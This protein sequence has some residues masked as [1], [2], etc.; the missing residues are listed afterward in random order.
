M[1]RKTRVAKIA[2]GTNAL[3]AA[4]KFSVG[5]MA[6]S[7]ALVADAADS[8]SDLVG[9]I[10]L[11]LGLSRAEA[12]PDD[13]HPYGHGKAEC[14]ASL[15]LGVLILAAAVT[16]LVR[17]ISSVGAAKHPVPGS[18]A[19]AAA[20]FSII[21]N[22]ALG[23]Y[24]HRSSKIEH[25]PGLEAGGTH[26]LSDS[27]TSVAALIGIYLARRGYP[28]ADPIVAGI[29][30]LLVGRVAVGIILDAGN[31]LMDRAAPEEIVRAVRE[32]ATG[33][34]GIWEVHSIRSRCSGSNYLLDLHIQVGPSISVLDGHELGHRLEE[35]ILSEVPG[36]LEVIVHVEPYLPE[37]GEET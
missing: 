30:S 16:L 28:L 4:V 22:L 2:I 6:K 36:V 18:L 26:A 14:L 23:L 12:P 7:S 34:P 24:M 33:F 35:E 19:L 29:V 31:K 21:V 1:S 27:A 5:L 32:T 17:A 8:S 10:F 13:N 15:A 3:L 25:S 9:D 20:G 37:N 11:L